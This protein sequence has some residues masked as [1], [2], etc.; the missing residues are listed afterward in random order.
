MTAGATRHL[1]ER[2]CIGCRAARPKRELIRLVLPA[3]GPVR[4]DPTGKEEGRGAYI[5]RQ[6]GTTCLTQAR[7][8]RVLVRAFRTTADRIDA[9]ALAGALAGLRPINSE[10]SPSPR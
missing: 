3:A 4:V 7:R 2:T 9:E 6:T 10:V 8:R 1:P 5:C